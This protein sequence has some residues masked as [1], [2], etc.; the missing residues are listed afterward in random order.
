LALIQEYVLLVVLVLR[1]N[2][3]L[4]AL[5]LQLVSVSHVI[6]AQ[7]ELT[8]YSVVSWLR[9]GVRRAIALLR[10]I[11]AVTAVG[12]MVDHVW[13]V[14]CARQVNIAEV[15]MASALASARRVKP[16]QEE[17]F[18]M[19]AMDCLLECVSTAINAQPVHFAVLLSIE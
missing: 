6:L 11:F 9:A 18:E 8:G 5:E 10:G 15:A 16:A 14:D 4:A 2:I 13:S 1:V 17:P 3:E 12:W 19:G 7:R